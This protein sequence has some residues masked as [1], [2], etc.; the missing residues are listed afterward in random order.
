MKTNNVLASGRTLTEGANTLE[1]NWKVILWWLVSIFRDNFTFEMD[2]LCIIFAIN[3]NC[4]SGPLQT[5]G[6]D[7]ANGYQDLDSLNMF[8]SRS[9]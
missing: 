3:A 6:R 5:P 4:S 2:P 9:E 8:P 1:V 7:A